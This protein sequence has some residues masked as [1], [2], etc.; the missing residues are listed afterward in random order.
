MFKTNLYRFIFVVKSKFSDVFYLREV[1]YKLE[2]KY[3][4]NELYSQVLNPLGEF[5]ASKKKKKKMIQKK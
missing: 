5:T 3:N 1:A 4:A 2:Q